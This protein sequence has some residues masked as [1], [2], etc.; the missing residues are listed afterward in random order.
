M[1]SSKFDRVD[2]PTKSLMTEGAGAKK[3]QSKPDKKLKHLAKEMLRQQEGDQP[4]R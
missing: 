3:R 2:E 1:P 4:K